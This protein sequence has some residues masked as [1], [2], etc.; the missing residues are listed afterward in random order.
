MRRE[1][2]VVFFPTNTFTIAYLV[3]S[4]KDPGAEIFTETLLRTLLR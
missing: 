1:Y 3:I 4:T 2:S